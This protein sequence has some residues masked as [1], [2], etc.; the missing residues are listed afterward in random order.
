MVRFSVVI[1]VLVCAPLVQ[2][3]ATEKTVIVL[4]D[5]TTIEATLEG[6]DRHGVRLSGGQVIAWQDAQSAELRD[7]RQREFDQFLREVG[8]PLFRIQHRLALGDHQALREYVEPLFQDYVTNY[9]RFNNSRTN[10]LICLA[11]LMSRLVSDNPSGAMLPFLHACRIRIED[12]SVVQR[13]HSFEL[14]DD[15]IQQM[16]SMRI[17]PIWFDRQ[18]AIDTVPLINEFREGLGGH[19]PIGVDIYWATL[20][21]AAGRITDADSLSRELA[22]SQM[23]EYWRLILEA[24]LERHT[25]AAS[26]PATDRL[27]GTMVDLPI[28]ARPLALYLV[29]AW[30]GRE[31]QDADVA[32]LELLRIPA[33]QGE[34]LAILSAAALHQ[35]A[36]ILHKSGRVE[37]SSILMRELI[38]RYPN[39]Y[40]GRTAK[41]ESQ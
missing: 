39:T 6:F 18:L 23:P 38:E 21:I 15:E 34:R 28:D 19:R 29:N 4:R 31:L 11:T 25:G 24:E 5:L 26:R 35:A 33:V 32:V 41:K 22:G 16:L 1:P 3:D 36:L 20:Q 13:S 8:T 7:E 27:Q 2:T 14:S 17:T 9:Q 30:R 40:H 37:E 10:Y 12:E